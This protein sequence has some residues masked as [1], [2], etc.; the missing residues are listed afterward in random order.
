MAEPAQTLTTRA[1]DL[2]GRTDS[3]KLFPDIHKYVVAHV[4]THTEINTSS[5]RRKHTTQAMYEV[6]LP[7]SDIT[8]GNH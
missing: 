3:H 1:N 7:F 5:E 4:C 2:K 8:L 6:S